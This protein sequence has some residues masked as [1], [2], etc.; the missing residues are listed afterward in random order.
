VLQP[1]FRGSTGFG[2]KFELAGYRQWG[3]AMQDDVTAGVKEMVA[4]GVA[5]PARICIFGGSYGGYAALWGLV[6]TPTLY[7]CGIS[8]AGVSDI[9]E[10]FSDWSDTND[11]EVGKEFRR[12]A[13]GDAD[14][15]AAQFDAVSP[16][17]HADQ[18]QVPVLLAHGTNDHRVPAGHSKRMEAALEKAH[19]SVETHWYSGEG[20]GLSK[21]A[22]LKDFNA[23]LLDFL[24]RNIGPASPLAGRSAAID[25][26]A[27]AA[28]TRS[29]TP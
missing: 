16:E 24:D 18:I 10:M 23:A 25:P 7:R 12:F 28:A 11:S 14:T 15:M 27:S 6:K 21:G 1:Q 22:D 19:K 8:L 20:H 4:R 29:T 13:V 9:G 17:K 26:A 2:H 3:L 5:D